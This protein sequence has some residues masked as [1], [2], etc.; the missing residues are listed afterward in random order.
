MTKIH[1]IDPLKCTRCGSHYTLGDSIVFARGC[2]MPVTVSFECS[3]R[4]IV[5]VHKNES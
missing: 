2:A 1:I 3:N 5:S 4:Q